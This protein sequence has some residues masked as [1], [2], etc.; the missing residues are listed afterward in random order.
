MPRTQRDS[1]SISQ[2][3]GLLFSVLGNEKR[4]LILK[5]L[6]E[7]GEVCVNTLAMRVQ[8]GQSALSQHL[9]R[10]RDIGIV[11]T[12]RERQA[13]YYRLNS[14]VVEPLISTYEGLVTRFGVKGQSPTDAMSDKANL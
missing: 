4:Y 14:P 13:I 3:A 8:M 12:R 10:M 1:E 5:V 2:Y 9:A 6:K 7:E 11:A